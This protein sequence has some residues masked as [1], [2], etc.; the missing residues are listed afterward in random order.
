M[1]ARLGF[2]LSMG[3]GFDTYLIDEVTAVGD[4]AFR[5]KCEAALA[6]RLTSR[7]AIVVSHSFGFLRRVCQAGVVIENGQAAWFGDLGEA[8]RVHRQTLETA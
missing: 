1:R 5:E 7:S 8:I 3:I 6:D 4:A 2:A